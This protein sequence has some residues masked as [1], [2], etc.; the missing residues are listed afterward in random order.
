M[1]GEKSMSR[2]EGYSRRGLLGLINHY[3]IKDIK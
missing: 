1:D 3:D 2:K